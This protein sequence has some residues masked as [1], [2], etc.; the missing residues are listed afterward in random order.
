M[1]RAQSNLDLDA[2]DLQGLAGGEP[3]QGEFTGTKALMLAVLEDGI[4]SYLGR[5]DR[6]AQEA[7]HWIQST[8]RR[9]P[10]SFMVVC[11]T[12]NLNPDA[13]RRVLQRMRG[14]RVPAGR[15]F[16]RTRPNARKPGRLS[17]HKGN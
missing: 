17:A 1:E 12:L 4:R 10:F 15:A 11:E 6:D 2:M 5:I 16:P 8:H 13:V 7:E 9:S 3:R 14:E